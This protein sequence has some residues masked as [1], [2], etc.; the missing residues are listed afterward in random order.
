[1]QRRRRQLP[2]GKGSGVIISADGVVLTNSHVVA[3]AQ[4]VVVQMTDGREFTVMEDDIL[5][6][7]G[8]DVAIV[9]INVSE[10]LPYM[11]LG[12][13]KEIEVGDWV[14]ALGSPFGLR[15]TV[16]QG[17]IS[18][19]ARAVATPGNRSSLSS[20]RTQRRPQEYLQTDAAINP[21]NSG[22]PLVNLR[23]EL[24]GINTAISTA[25]GGYDGVG[26]A[27]P[28]STAKWVA[29]Q[30]LQSGSVQRG[31][32]GILMQPID[33]EL[34]EHF[35]LSVPHGVV[36]VEVIEDSP[37]EKA[38]F[39]VG[40]VIL[41][42][43]DRNISSHINLAGI[44]ERLNVGSTYPVTILRNEEQIELTIN[45]GQRPR[46]QTLTRTDSSTSQDTSPSD[47]TDYNELGMVV[48]ELTPELSSQLNVSDRGVLIAAVKEG[49]G[50]ERAGLEP[51]M[52]ISR[53]G[54]LNVSG[55]DEFNRV[56][57]ESRNPEKVLLLVVLPGNDTRNSSSK[58]VVV[59]FDDGQS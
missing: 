54:N 20:A 53:V 59:E 56:L 3:D 26:F 22:G 35:A 27:V 28:V 5:T 19:K 25:S 50:A 55:V 15:S 32:L 51:G 42:V 31:F 24:V 38:G 34:A 29:D 30:L 2:S 14:L 44:V 18:A 47:S 12:D 21:G 49:S 57:Q 1:M 40:D 6:D 37:A 41:A 46:E 58:F 11:P 39:Q 48:Q 43:N 23:G 9:R 13:D 8:T 7:P 36:V 10:E 17:I 45:V 52:V 33:A 4:E 16:T